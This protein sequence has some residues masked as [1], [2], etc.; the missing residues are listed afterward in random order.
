M[1]KEAIAKAVA[2][3]S[4]TEAEAEAVMREIM[5][6]EA[7]DAQIAAYITALRMKGETVEEIT[8]SAR[9][10]RE[11]AVHVKLSA[12]F[13]VDTCGTGGDLSHTFNISTTVAFVVAGGGVSVAKHGN[14]SV[15]SKSGSA[16]VLQALG[17]NIEMPVQ[18]V[19]E[20]LAEVGIAFLFAPMMHQAMKFAIGPRREIGI[21]TIFNLLGP[22]TNPAGAR[23]QLLGVSTQDHMH[24]LGDALA[25]MGCVHA[26]VA[27]GD[28]GMDELSVTGCSQA[29]E[30]TS[31]VAH[32]CSKIAPEDC[33]LTRHPL[34]TLAGG[35]A[36]TNAA[37]TRDVLGGKSGGPRDAV[38]MNAAA[39]LYVAD[40]VLSLPDGVEL[41]RTSI[42]S[43]AALAVLERMIEVTNRLAGEGAAAAPGGGHPAGRSGVVAA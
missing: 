12:P 43:G 37:I 2:G 5:E 6:G 3:T 22:L 9:V 39:A 30:V 7:T 16:D 20:C 28:L 11:K 15:S 21:R 27:C 42:D 26:L 38:L 8:G 19:E 1:I 31:G 4:L 24:V 33:G 34:E 41:A 10:M 25:R 29:I 14:R 35:D 23:R 32:R 36:A 17:V 40:R 13:Q 18:R